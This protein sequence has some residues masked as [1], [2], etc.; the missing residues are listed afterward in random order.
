MFEFEGIVSIIS[1]A[2]FI[3]PTNDQPWKCFI[4]SRPGG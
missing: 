4:T 2:K 1:I 3:N